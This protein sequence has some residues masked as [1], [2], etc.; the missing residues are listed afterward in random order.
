MSKAA[1]EAAV[2]DAWL[3]AAGRSAAQHLGGVRDRIPCG[4]SVGIA[5]STEVMLEEIQ[6]Y[7]AKGYR[8]VKLKIEPGR[9]VGVVRAI[10]EALP[11]TPLSV[12]A[13][14]AY[15]LAAA[16]MF[17]ALDEL[18][19]V[20]IEQPLHEEDLLNHALLQSRLDGEA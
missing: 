12:D 8:R 14:A 15:Q 18:G 10:R 7:L 4:V 20:M 11:D 1:L 19:L 16:P 17:E 5:P 13:N 3:R 2:L 9:D 6:G